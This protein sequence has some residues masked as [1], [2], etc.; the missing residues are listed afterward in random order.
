SDDD[1]DYDID[2]EEDKE[3]EEHLAPGDFTTVTLPVVDHAPS[4][5]ETEP[6]E[7]DESAATP[8]P[9]PAY[10]VTARISI[11]DELPTP[12][13]SD[14]E[15]ARLLVIPTPPPSPLSLWSSPLPQIPSTP[16]P[17]ILSPLPVSPPL[18]VSSPPPASLIRLLGYRVAMIRL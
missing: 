1:E 3:E 13:W 10:R 12:F 2:I 4:A 14:T 8:P 18:L 6:F 15:V 9:H 16:L 17:P 11:R 7:T 5:E